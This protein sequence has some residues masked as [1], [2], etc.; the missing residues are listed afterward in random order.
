ME[1]SAEDVGEAEDVKCNGREKDECVKLLNLLS[2][3]QSSASAALWPP[4]DTA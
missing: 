4:S 1:G 2:L 3:L